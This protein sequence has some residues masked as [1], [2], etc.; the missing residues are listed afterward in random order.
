MSTLTEFP[1]F[2]E[3]AQ[4]IQDLIWEAAMRRPTHGFHTLYFRPARDGKDKYGVT[5]LLGI[6]D[7]GLVGMIHGYNDEKPQYTWDPRSRITHVTLGTPRYLGQQLFDLS[8]R[9]IHMLDFRATNLSLYIEDAALWTTCTDSRRAMNRFHRRPPPIMPQPSGQ[10]SISSATEIT[11]ESLVPTQTREVVLMGGFASDFTLS[12]EETFDQKFH[13]MSEDLVCVQCDWRIADPLRGAVFAAGI[14]GALKGVNHLA[15]EFE[16]YMLNSLYYHPPTRFIKNDDDPSFYSLVYD[17]PLEW[18]EAVDAGNTVAALIESAQRS[19]Q[20]RPR[21]VWLI[22]HAIKRVSNHAA[23]SEDQGAL[24]RAVFHGN[25]C[26]LTEVRLGDQGWT[27]PSMEPG[28]QCSVEAQRQ[29]ARGRPFMLSSMDCGAH[30]G[31]KRLLNRIIENNQAQGMTETE[32][33]EWFQ[34]GP[35]RVL[36]VEY[37][38]MRWEYVPR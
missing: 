38:D 4:E 5:G 28:H 22:D 13:I 7:A 8:Y 21:T 6:R 15:L 11:T 10:N 20:E 1:K 14:C 19:H 12:L 30:C 9:E 2:R 26:K 25:G 24:E 27:A 31:I 17:P 32:L 36:A 29:F 33:F 18:D 37:E 3:L 35:I 34:R 23:I 16:K